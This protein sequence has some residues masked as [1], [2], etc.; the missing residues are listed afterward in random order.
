MENQT[1]LALI[2]ELALG[3][4]EVSNIFWRKNLRVSEKF[5][6]VFFKKKMILILRRNFN[7]RFLVFRKC[8]GASR[9]NR[10]LD[11]VFFPLIIYLPKYEPYFNNLLVAHSRN[12]PNTLNIYLLGEPEETSELFETKITSL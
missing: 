3:R 5:P 8:I 9:V 7:V 1:H 11:P 4:I 6:Q 12:M 2:G 10:I